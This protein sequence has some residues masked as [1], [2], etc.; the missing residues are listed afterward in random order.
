MKHI[1]AIVVVAVFL[2]LLALKLTGT[3]PVA[4]WS[5]WWVTA[6]LWVALIGTVMMVALAFLVVGARRGNTARQRRGPRWG[7]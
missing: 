6:P 1:E 2:V 7:A 5:W 3:G 4:H